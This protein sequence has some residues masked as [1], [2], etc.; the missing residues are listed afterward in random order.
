M[1]AGIRMLHMTPA[2][3]WLCQCGTLAPG[4]F[5]TVE[6]LLPL[7]IQNVLHGTH[8]IEWGVMGAAAHFTFRTRFAHLVQ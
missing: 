6:G 2:L 8:I 1:S 7:H 5:Q 4:I 3:S